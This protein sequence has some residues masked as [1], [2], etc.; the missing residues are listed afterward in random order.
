MPWTRL[1]GLLLD[2]GNIQFLKSIT[3]TGAHD[4]GYTDPVLHSDNG[5]PLLVRTRVPVMPETEENPVIALPHVHLRSGH[6]DID[7]V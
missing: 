4:P 7:G 2:I 5:D 1:A 6:M 3:I